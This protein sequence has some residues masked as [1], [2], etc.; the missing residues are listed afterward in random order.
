M[1]KTCLGYKALTEMRALPCIFQRLHLDRSSF[2]DQTV[3]ASWEFFSRIDPKIN[4]ILR[5]PLHLALCLAFL[6]LCVR[7]YM[8]MCVHLHVPPTGK[9]QSSLIHLHLFPC[10]FVWDS[11]WLNLDL[12]DS[13]RL[14]GQQISEILMVLPPQYY[15]P[16]L[17][18]GFFVFLFFC[19]CVSFF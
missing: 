3:V 9:Y 2:L 13:S 12:A 10:L 18:R 1:N 6:F 7:G 15:R 19:V 4:N 17:C 14:A 11:L 5:M 16:V 8:C